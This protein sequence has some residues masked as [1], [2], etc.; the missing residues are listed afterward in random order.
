MCCRLRNTFKRGRCCVPLSL[1]RMRRWRRWRAARVSMGLNISVDLL[2]LGAGLAVLASHHF[3]G[4][5]DALGFVWL[6]WTDPSHLRGYLADRLLVGATDGDRIALHGE[7]DAWRGG[8]EHRV[9]EADLQ[10][11]VAGRN[12]SAITDAVD[13]QAPREAGRHARHHVRD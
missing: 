12:G 11:Q 13:F 5:L 9:R 10:H 6:G 3:L 8:H 4:V 7:T 1:T 2:L